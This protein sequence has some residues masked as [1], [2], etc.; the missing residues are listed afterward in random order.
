M[1]IFA[2]LLLF[3]FLSCLKNLQGILH[4]FFL[5]LQATSVHNVFLELVLS[6]CGYFSG[7][8]PFSYS[9]SQT[10]GCRLLEVW[11]TFFIVAPA[12]ER[13]RQFNI[14]GVFNTEQTFGFH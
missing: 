11:E 9:V 4:P 1:L 14:R 13:I 2:W 10:V 5:P 7:Q 6:I 8:V 12:A 3:N